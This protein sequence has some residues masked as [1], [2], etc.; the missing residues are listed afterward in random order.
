[1]RET[2]TQALR[3]RAPRE[4]HTADPRGGDP[5]N[6]GQALE[7][8]RAAATLSVVLCHA[9]IAY[10]ATPMR[11]TNWSVYDRAH[12][13]V[14]DACIY[15]VNGWAMPLFFLAAGVSATAACESRGARVFLTH[16][17]RRLLKPLL[18]GTLTV[19]PI[20]YII[21]AYGLIMTDRCDLMDI[22]SWR[23]DPNLNSQ[24]YGLGHFWFLEY[25][26]VVCVVW[27]AGWWLCRSLRR[28]S[29]VDPAARVFEGRIPRAFS[30][31]WKPLLLAVPTVLIFSLDSDTMIRLGNELVPNLARVL[32]Y[33]YFFAV[34][35]W[36]SQVKDPKAR[37]IPYSTLYAVLS[38][39]VCIL[40]IPLMMRHA[41]APA[42]GMERYAVAV[43]SGLFT[44]LSVLGGLGVLMRVIEGRNI[45]LRYLSEASLWVYIIHVPI[46]TLM[47]TLLLPLAWPSPI[48]FLL[49]AI[50][51][52]GLSLLSYEYAVRYS[53]VGE[54]VNGA[55]KRSKTSSR[56]ARELGWVVSVVV[57]LVGL[58]AWIWSFHGALWGINFGEVVAGNVYRC[59]RL[60]PREL[61]GLIGRHGMR[62]V[63]VF[64]GN[65]FQHQWYIAQ[66]RVCHD[67]GV[68]L[69]AFQLNP[70]QLPTRERLEAMIHVIE[71]SPRPLLIEGN[72]NFKLSGFASAVAE[73]LQGKAPPEALREFSQKYGDIGGPEH[74]VLAAVLL[75][76]QRE[77]E[78]RG[79]SHSPGRFRDWA[80]TEYLIDSQPELPGDPRLRPPMLA[81]ATNTSVIVR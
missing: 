45:G 11:L 1:M 42:R 66:Q 77:L 3:Q 56:F 13:A 58:G 17:A 31:A 15:W 40:Y 34:G 25:L 47:Q 62:S 68:K 16:R 44:W 39:A 9:A 52:L 51:G 67:R 59:G 70:D 4:R 55:R 76:Y 21:M 57:V 7:A 35:A 41:A 81:E 37:L 50:V 14:F 18:F 46:V 72:R 5:A 71:S 61:D 78:R 2:P 69:T 12:S 23:F 48:K 73:L 49:V 75:D 29:P 43:A 24:L 26:Y 28:L 54:I 19:L 65:P 10:M 33:T 32:H 20:Y 80:R 60:S 38:F 27:C 22:M 53:L 36:I 79:Q 74:S 63:L 64:T 8:F 30:T 6:I